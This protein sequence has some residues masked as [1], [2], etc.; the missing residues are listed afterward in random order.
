MLISQLLILFY[1]CFLVQ[2]CK[3]QFPDDSTNSKSSLKKKQKRAN[4]EKVALEKW[5]TSLTAKDYN[6]TEWRAKF[7]SRSTVD[8]FNGYSV[9]LSNIF[10]E[11]GAK[12]NFVMIGMSDNLL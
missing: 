2:Q 10:K 6:Y 8:F 11:N 4:P 5:A 3:C 7:H 12:V 1:V 9:K